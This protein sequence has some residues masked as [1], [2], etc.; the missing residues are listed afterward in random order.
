MHSHEHDE[1]AAAIAEDGVDDADE[2]A[3]AEQAAEEHAQCAQRGE[4]LFPQRDPT[5]FG[6]EHAYEG[7]EARQRRAEHRKQ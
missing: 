7:H 3:E 6:R 4:G 1:H 2:V 5:G